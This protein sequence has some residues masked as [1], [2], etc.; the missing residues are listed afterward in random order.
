M[1]HTAPPS[2]GLGSQRRNLAQLAHRSAAWCGP[3]PGVFTASVAPQLGHGGIGIV[4]A[5]GSSRFSWRGG[6]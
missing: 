3:A 1:N 6:F 4:T 5:S 2:L